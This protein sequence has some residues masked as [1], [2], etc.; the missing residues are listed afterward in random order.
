MP[1]YL[2]NLIVTFLAPIHS[3]SY[4]FNAPDPTR[5][6]DV[7]PQSGINSRKKINI[8]TELHLPFEYHI[9]EKEKLC[10]KEVE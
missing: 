3:S 10:T 9:K 2:F 7:Y 8:D 4:S 1:L 6:K 5:E